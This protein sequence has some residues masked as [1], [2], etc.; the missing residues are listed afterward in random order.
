MRFQHVAGMQDIMPN[1]SRAFKNIVELFSSY[2][3]SFGYE[4]LVSPLLEDKELYVRSAG[5]Q[6]D[7]VNKEMYE[8]V[9]KSGNILVLRPEGT[10]SVA[11]AFIEHNPNL[12]FKV[13]YLT[14]AFRYERPQKG[15]L[16]Q[17]HQLG[18][19][20]FGTRDFLADV[21]VIFILNNLFD[22]LAIKD[23]LL[24][25]N[26]MGEPDCREGYLNYLRSYLRNL[27]TK[28]CSDHRLRYE[29]NPLR[30]L[31]C[32]KAECKAA[33]QNVNQ[34]IDYVCQS[35]RD[36][37]NKTCS[38]LTSLGISYEVD[39]RLVRGF[40]YYT[41]TTFEFISPSLGPT[42]NALGGGGR[43]DNLVSS[44][45]GKNMPA[46]GGAVGVERLMLVNNKLTDNIDIYLIASRLTTAL[47]ILDQ[48]SVLKK[49]IKF[50]LSHS[51]IVAGLKKANKLK[52]SFALIIGKSEIES[53][54]VT[55]KNMKT[56][57]QQTVKTEMLVEYLKG[58]L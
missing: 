4:L 55:V 25:I 45:G 19:E 56:S 14:P 30:V 10:A 54:L 37:F 28:L 35:C 48:L 42:Q 17:H 21:E 39:F 8:L 20:Y 41:K 12:P 43:Y 32:K 27:E 44:L 31:D 11:R 29:K 53:N 57:E 34:L 5:Q 18:I 13:W 36:H 6:S 33:T 47:P 15:R 9:D 26:T 2:V 49:R 24:K 52:A 58:V 51:S 50:D 3:E 1:D 16:R 23:R 7:V 46:V 22:K 40:D 38:E